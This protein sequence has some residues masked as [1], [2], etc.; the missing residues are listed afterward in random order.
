MSDGVCEG[1]SFFA[2]PHTIVQEKSISLLQV[3]GFQSFLSSLNGLGGIYILYH[4]SDL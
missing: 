3:K 2:Y 1:D 4:G